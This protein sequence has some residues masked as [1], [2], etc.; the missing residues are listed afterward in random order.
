MLSKLQCKASRLL[1]SALLGL[2]STGVNAASLDY[3]TNFSSG[4]GGE[5]SLATSLNT[6]AAGILGQL[7]DGSATLSIASPGVGS[8]R[9]TFDLL[10]FNSV[11]GQ[12]PWQDTFN[13]V[14]NGSVI[15]TGT[16]G[17]GGGGADFVSLQPLD[18]VVTVA[19]ERVRNIAIDIAIVSGMNSI[20]FDYG[21][22]QG[23]GDESWGLDNVGLSATVAAVPEPETYA[24][25]LAGLGLVGF[26]AR[27]RKRA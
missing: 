19:D 3:S 12:N 22:M 2:A 1:A 20:R 23:I 15:F 6:G 17:M 21:A 27:R 4:V 10:G 14:V 26:A 8:G 16:F 13:L 5:W 25:M 7:Q 9:L 24:L 11:D 18:T